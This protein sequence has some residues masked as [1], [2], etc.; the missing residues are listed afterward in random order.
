MLT[1]VSLLSQ[2]PYRC[3]APAASGIPLISTSYSDGQ[4]GY[5]FIAVETARHADKNGITPD[6]K[7]GINAREPLRLRHA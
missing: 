3:V 6:P 7:S 4:L 1:H 2:S 5:R